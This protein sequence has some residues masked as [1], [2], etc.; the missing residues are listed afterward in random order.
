[1]L[2]QSH[3]LTL[4]AKGFDSIKLKTEMVNFCHRVLALSTSHCNQSGSIKPS[5]HMTSK[6]RQIATSMRRNNVTSMSLSRNY[7]LMCLLGIMVLIRNFQ[8]LNWIGLMNFLSTKIQ[9]C[10]S[11]FRELSFSSICNFE[12]TI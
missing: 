7:Y 12:I 8:H 10:T 2:A 5:E 11:N 9:K 3:T 6:L 4:W 1:M